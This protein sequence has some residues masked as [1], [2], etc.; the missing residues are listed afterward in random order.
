MMIR[1][2]G[3]PL[4]ACVVWLSGTGCGGAAPP[5]HA[6]TDA[7]AAVRA[8]R[9]LGA[10]GTPQASYHLAL[11][12]D[13]VERA[14]DMVARGHNEQAQD[15]LEFAKADAEL[16]MALQREAAVRAHALETHEHLQEQRDT[17]IGT[18]GR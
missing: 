2:W 14:A 9:E 3:V 12:D 18:E 4:A 15:L 17:T 7:V 10:E 1:T 8:A 16:A 11:A 5:I 13:Q 6:Q